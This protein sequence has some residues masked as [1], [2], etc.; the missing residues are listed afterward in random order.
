MGSVSFRLF[1]IGLHLAEENAGVNFMDSMSRVRYTPAP[2]G[3]LHL[4]SQDADYIGLHKFEQVVYLD[5]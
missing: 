2:F 1:S 5:F 4:K 3:F